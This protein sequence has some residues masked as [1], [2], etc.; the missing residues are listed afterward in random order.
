VRWPWQRAADE[1]RAL[2]EAEERLAKVREQWA[3]V[4]E[5]AA[6]SRL[7]K[8]RNHFGDTIATIYRGR[9]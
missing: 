6:E 8:R 5:V 3:D 7:H 2:R 1:E 9:T 4:H